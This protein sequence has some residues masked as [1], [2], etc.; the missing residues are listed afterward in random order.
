MKKIRLTE[1]NLQQLVR[2][3]IKEV[4]EAPVKRSS[5]DVEVWCECGDVEGCYGSWGGGTSVNCKCC[6]ELINPEEMLRGPGF[7][8]IAEN[9]RLR[10]SRR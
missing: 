4:E 2:R 5:G 10:R 3:V 6:D 7:N 8:Q 9:K 1:R